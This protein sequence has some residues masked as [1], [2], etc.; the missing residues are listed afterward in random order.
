MS[1]FKRHMLI[2]ILISTEVIWLLLLTTQEINNIKK[3]HFH[4]LM[5]FLKMHIIM[6]E[7]GIPLRDIVEIY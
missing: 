3:A 7:F 6:E 1:I 4:L 2:K 5:L